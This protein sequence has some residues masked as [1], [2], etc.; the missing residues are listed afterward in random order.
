M[1]EIFISLSAFTDKGN[2]EELTKLDP[3]AEVPRPNI[4]NLQT[5]K[6]FAD[7]FPKIDVPVPDATP[8]VDQE[9]T[10][11][12]RRVAEAALELGK[13][14]ERHTQYQLR[15]LSRMSVRYENNTAPNENI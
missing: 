7:I 2:D 8:D 10:E 6:R 13:T 3:V 1:R 11:L 14:P 5:P 9:I 12:N 4:P 15:R